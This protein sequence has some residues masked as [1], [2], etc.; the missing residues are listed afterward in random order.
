MP[1]TKSAPRRKRGAAVSSGPKKKQAVAAKKK[2]AVAAKKKHVRELAKAG[3]WAEIEKLYGKKILVKA[4]MCM[5][6]A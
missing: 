5:Y 3:R 2:Q 4:K 1:A 6:S